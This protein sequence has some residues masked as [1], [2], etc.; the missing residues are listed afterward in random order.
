VYDAAYLEPALRIRHL[1]ARLDAVAPGD[2]VGATRSAA[3]YWS[4]IVKETRDMSK[5]KP[6]MS[7]V[8]AL[9]VTSHANDASAQLSLF[10]T[11][12]Q[13]Q[14]HCPDDTVVWLNSDKR[15]YYVVGQR[16]Y[17]Q[18]KKGVFVCQK[19]ART[20]GYRRSLL[21]RR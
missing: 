11:D 5:K 12:V 15:I 10:Q 9:V 20:T 19:E 17:A 18:G 1:L 14:Q 7:L 3:Q 4:P 8:I 16:L 13:A 2:P 21:G 6:W